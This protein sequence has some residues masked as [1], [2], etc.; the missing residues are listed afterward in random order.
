VSS[1]LVDGIFFL[2]NVLMIAS[3]FRDRLISWIEQGGEL[4][5]E[6]AFDAHRWEDRD[7]RTVISSHSIGGVTTVKRSSA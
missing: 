7:I 1:K 6:A 3:K 4:I 5:I 2:I